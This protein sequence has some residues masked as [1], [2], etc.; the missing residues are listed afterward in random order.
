M[1]EK[2]LKEKAFTHV[3]YG[4]MNGLYPPDSLLNEKGLCEEL[5]ISKS[6]VREALVDL[7]SQGILRSIPRHGYEVVRYTEQNIQDIVQYRLLVECGCLEQSFDSIT[8]TQLCV[9]SDMV[10]REFTY[11]SNKDTLVYWN[12]TLDFHLTLASFAGNEFIFNQLK[13]ALNT[14][15]RAYLQFYWDKWED[16]SS[17]R[18]SELHLEIVEQIRRRQKK[19]AIACLEEDIRSIFKFQSIGA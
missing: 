7:C 9:L 11:L 14:L 13:T 17:L 19:Q 3:L 6:P 1:P 12:D 2:T 8:S 5:S 10:E 15:M 16:H 4:I 18:P